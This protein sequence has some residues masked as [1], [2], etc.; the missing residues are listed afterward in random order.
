MQNFVQNVG[1]VLLQC[2]R[3]VLERYEHSNDDKVHTESDMFLSLKKQERLN[4]SQLLDHLLLC[5]SLINQLNLIFLISNNN[6]SAHLKQ[7]GG[8][9]VSGSCS[10]YQ[11]RC[12][13]AF[14]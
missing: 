6:G 7:N 10:S 3:N 1:T 5:D 2:I 4:A 12:N 8:C 14:S 9:I 11:S 13:L